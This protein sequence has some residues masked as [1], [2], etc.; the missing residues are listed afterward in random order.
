[1]V[2]GLGK[3]HS[4]GRPGGEED[5]GEPESHVRRATLKDSGSVLPRGNEDPGL[6]VLSLSTEAGHLGFNAVP[7]NLELSATNSNF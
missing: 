6:Q 1:M 3:G 7:L 4:V 2:Q 5:W